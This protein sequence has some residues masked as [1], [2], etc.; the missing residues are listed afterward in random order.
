METKK[1]PFI[2]THPHLAD[3]ASLLHDLNKESERGAVLI[4]SAYI[5]GQ[6]KKIIA[7]FLLR[8]AASKKLL[9]EFSGPLGTFVARAAAAEALG[10]ISEDEGSDLTVIRKIRNEFAHNHRAA[11]SDE[12]IA[13]KCHL[14]KHRVKDTDACGQFTTAAVSFD[15]NSYE[16]LTLRFA[17]ASKTRDLALLSVSVEEMA[18]SSPGSRPNKHAFRQAFSER[19][20]HFSQRRKLAQ[21][22]EP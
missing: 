17:K 15:T 22:R 19:R 11:F 2:E 21:M 20:G 18:A 13:Q 7:A 1:H 4:S 8:G 16:P 5:E 10:L 14:L 12:H 6:L 3:F 9:N